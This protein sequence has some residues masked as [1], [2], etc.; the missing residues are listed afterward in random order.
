MLQ[1]RASFY[2]D[3]DW[4]HQKSSNAHQNDSSMAETTQCV[5]GKPPL[6]GTVTAEHMDEVNTE[7]L[8]QLLCDYDVSSGIFYPN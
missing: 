2:D 3:M 1:S 5:F 6:V 4:S 7:G 8:I